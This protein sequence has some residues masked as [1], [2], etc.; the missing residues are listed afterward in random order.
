MTSDQHLLRCFTGKEQLAICQGSRKK[1][2]ID[3]D[4]IVLIRHG[5]PELV[6]QAKAP[7]IGKITPFGKE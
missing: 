5:Q 3:I 4:A 2:A 1:L 7:I 6:R